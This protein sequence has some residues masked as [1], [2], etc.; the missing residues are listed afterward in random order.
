[1]TAEPGLAVTILSKH[2]EAA[3][4]WMSAFA[5]GAELAN[6]NVEPTLA[7]TIIAHIAGRAIM[8]LIEQLTKP[9]LNAQHQKGRQ[10]GHQE[11]RQDLSDLK[12]R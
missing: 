7:Y 12:Q 8:T 6:I 1:M 5:K 11:G 10:E 2:G 3:P 9:L 4:A